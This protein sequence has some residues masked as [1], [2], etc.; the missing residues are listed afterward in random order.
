MKILFNNKRIKKLGTVAHTHRLLLA[1]FVFFF[2]FSV[3]VK[4]IA[5]PLYNPG[6]TLDPTCAPGA[7]DCTVQIIPSQ[8]GNSGKYLT[9]NGTTASWGTVAGGTTYTFSTGLTDTADTITNNLS[10]GVSGG[11]SVVGGTAGGND[12]TLSSTSN[13]TKGKIIFGNSAY[14]EANNRL[15]IG[16][17]S[18]TTVVDISFDNNNG[19]AVNDTMT[20]RNSNNGSASYAG[21]VFKAGTAGEGGQIF[22]SRSALDAYGLVDGLTLG[23]LDPAQ[24]IGFRV[25]T[26]GASNGPNVIIK[27]SGN[28]GVGDAT[29]TALFT[30]GSG[31]LFQVNSSGAIAAATGITS[32][33]TINFSG[34]TASQLI[35]TDASKN[36]QSL[37]TAT[38]PSLT[39]FSYLKGVTSS[40]QTQINS[41]EAA[42]TFSTGLTRSTNTI[43]N[44]LSTGVSGGQSL[45]GDTGP[46]G[47]L[48][49]S[50]TSDSTK[51]QVN[52]GNIYFDEANH[53]LGIGTPTP[54]AYLDVFGAT[55]QLRLA[56][57]SNKHTTF[58][59]DSGGDMT[60]TP[61]GSDTTITGNLSVSNLTASR[62]LTTNSSNKLASSAT[63]DTELGYVSGV[64]SAIQTQL[65][66]KGTFT[67]PSLTTGSVLFSNGSTIAQDNSNF[68][69]DDSSNELGIGTAT[70]S[71]YLHVL[72]TTEQ[73]RLGYDASNYLSTT[74]GSTGSTTFAGT[75]TNT[76]MTFTNSGTGVFTFNSSATTGSALAFNANSL[77]TGTGLNVVSSSLTSGS[78]AS[79]V[80]T[81][82]GA[83]GDTQ[84]V[85]GIYN[86]GSTG[87]QTTFGLKVSNAHSNSGAGVNIGIESYA[88]G[89]NTASYAIKGGRDTNSYFTIATDVSSITTFAANG[90]LV[91]GTGS[92]LTERARIT[93]TGNFGIGTGSTVSAKLHLI[94]TT[95]QQR[96]GYDVSNYYSTTVGST[97]AVTFDATGSGSAFLFNDKIGMGTTPDARLHI[98]STAEQLRLG[99]DASNYVTLQVN[100]TGILTVSPVSAGVGDHTY[101]FTDDGFGI[102]DSTPNSLFAVGV[103]SP[104]Q[105]NTSG[106]IAAATGIT[107]SGTITFSGIGTNNGSAA[108][109][110]SAGVVTIASSS[111]TVPSALR[112]KHNIEDLSGNLEKVIALR[113][114]SYVSN[115]DNVLNIGFIAEEVATVENRLVSY[116]TT[117]EVM[118]LN[119]AQFA[120]LF[121]GAI[122]ELDL[123]V[124][125]IENFST[126][127]TFATTLISW[128]SN[129]SN[130][131]TRIFT[132][133]ICLVDSDGNSE[134]LN[135]IELMQ[136]KSLLSTPPTPSVNMGGG[137]PDVVPDENPDVTPDVVPGDDQVITEGEPGPVM[138]NTGDTTDETT[139]D[140]SSGDTNSGDTNSGSDPGTTGTGDML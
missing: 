67:L 69:W 95:E 14:D 47:T 21:I 118:G 82:T 70:P 63:T 54:G 100:S 130:R 36:L 140:V 135:K 58:T 37:D 124:V 136:L 23:A 134:C 35:A 92:S 105:V 80:S 132:G 53:Q 52:I 83:T 74:V 32:S 29:P 30:V 108:L 59:T 51:G 15:G 26:Q 99:Y 109:C 57:A 129:A 38:Y 91:L 16:T 110:I 4:V 10:T 60:I 97:G 68:F 111:C 66:A 42:L 50:S 6:D 39:E 13:A 44:N 86:A 117:G 115:I 11:Q 49:I 137:T 20:L 40:V 122:K 81:S 123:K 112:F 19:N 5:A 28:M 31:D 8:T 101:Y 133:E 138:D 107:S 41:K 73:Q 120:P 90:T 12:L 84:T 27:A 116:N 65:N 48:N 127:S 71:A 114:V 125:G 119:Y 79:F 87:G 113:P 93:S 77:T 104:F 72:G 2:L 22:G 45:Y 7:V 46:G 89:A 126:D 43:T 18:P 78:L 56:Y 102:D 17:T 85:V 98:L 96:T 88:S 121:A 61:N 25:G 75:G 62:A 94:S 139:G 64:T 1:S 9:T 106:A 55:T 128:L 103:G 131:I 34:L 24:D 76:G 33:G 3:V